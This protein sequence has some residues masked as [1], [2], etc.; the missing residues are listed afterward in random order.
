MG[1]LRTRLCS[2]AIF[3]ILTGQA[4]ALSGQTLSDQSRPDPAHLFA[5]CTGRLSAWM[6]FQWLVQ[7]QGADQTRALRDAMADLLDAATPVA[8]RVSAMQLRLEAK[9]AAADLFLRGW[10]Q[11]DIAAQDRARAL[12]S[13]CTDLLVS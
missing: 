2:L 10:R 1:S 5:I 9:V 11:R 4:P 6:E 7:D 8:Q 12:L 13:V 3:L